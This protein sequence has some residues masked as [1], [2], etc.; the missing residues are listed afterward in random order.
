MLVFAVLG[1]VG[2]LIAKAGVVLRVL[3]RPARMVRRLLS[4]FLRVPK[5]KKRRFTARGK[6]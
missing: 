1:V 2:D 5:E 6:R 4:A 3:Y